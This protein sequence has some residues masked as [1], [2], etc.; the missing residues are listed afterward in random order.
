[1]AKNEDRY[2]QQNKKCSVELVICRPQSGLRC[3]VQTVQGIVRVW[4]DR[5]LQNEEKNE[6][7]YMFLR[8]RKEVTYAQS[9]WQRTYKI[10]SGYVQ[11]GPQSVIL[12]KRKTHRLTFIN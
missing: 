11:I 9:F 8:A 4:G 3:R 7:I 1:M 5:K 10:F 2:S 6:K 12:G